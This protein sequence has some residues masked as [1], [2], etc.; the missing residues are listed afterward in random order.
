MELPGYC[1]FRLR[2]HLC[3]PAS[4]ALSQRP[5]H[6]ASVW[7]R[8]QNSFCEAKVQEDGRSG[9]GMLEVALAAQNPVLYVYLR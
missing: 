2:H 1:Q 5:S 7:S 4:R 6:P 9:L 8:L 3:S